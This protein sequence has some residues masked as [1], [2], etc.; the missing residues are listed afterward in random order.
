MVTHCF[1]AHFV[2]V[3]VDTLTGKV[4]VV[5]LV[6]AHD[7]GKAVNPINIE[8][9]IEGGCTMGLGYALTEEIKVNAGKI[10]TNNLATYLIP[11]A[12][13]VPEVHS[14]IVEEPEETGPFGAKGV[15][16][17]SL[18]PTAAA[19][20]NAVYNAIGIRFT[21]LPI[22]PEKVLAELQSL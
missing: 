3:E 18:I 20:A 4:R 19:I 11:T 15:G 14:M 13:D 8:G 6:A 22:T 21:T 9:Q 16:E 12:L 5:K 1:A 10:L 7:V 2:E 17:P